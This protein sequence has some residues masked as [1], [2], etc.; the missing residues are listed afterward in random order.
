MKTFV[1]FLVLTFLPVVACSEC[2]I[3]LHGLARTDK[4]MSKLEQKLQAENFFTVNVDYPSR[5]YPI[6]YLA[7]WYIPPALRECPSGD[8]IS[9]VTHSLGG[10]LVRQ[11]LANHKIENLNRVVMLGPPNQGSEVVDKL[12]N[13][14]GFELING[15]AGLQLGTGV[16]SVP[17]KL[18]KPDFEVGII[19]GTNSINLILSLLIPGDDD[20]KISIERTKL[21]GMNDH[22]ELPVSHPFLMK[23]DAAI[24]QVINFLKFGAFAR[25][26]LSH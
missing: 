17:N 22:I 11:Y 2:V 10:I 9:F 15:Q 1:T 25:E 8:E 18:G 23:D 4:S 19:A 7:E 24:D 6:E 16:A 3:L 12:G 20:G 5:H 14:A 26:Q 13:M 21:Q